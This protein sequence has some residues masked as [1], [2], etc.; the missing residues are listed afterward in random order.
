M[1]ITLPDGTVF[2]GTP[3][4]YAELCALLPHLGRSGPGP[5]EAP[6]AD[7]V[8]ELLARVGGRITAVV[9]LDYDVTERDTIEVDFRHEPAEVDEAVIISLLGTRLNELQAEVLAAAVAPERMVLRYEC[10]LDAK[11]VTTEI[12]T[13][14]A[15]A[16][17][18]LT[19]ILLEQHLRE[20]MRAVVSLADDEQRVWQRF[21]A[22]LELL[23]GPDDP[24]DVNVDDD[25]DGD[26]DD[27]A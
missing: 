8:A 14:P 27:A 26:V 18:M 20:R 19:L 7:A 9:E 21:D 11:T 22:Q 12:E 16:D 17:P 25:D 10:D 5:E 4:E 3:A 6:G 23:L 2:E 24:E 1:K 15:D 13:E